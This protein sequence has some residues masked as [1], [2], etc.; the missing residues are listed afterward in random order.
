MPHAY[1]HEPTRSDTKSEQTHDDCEWLNEEDRE[2]DVLGYWRDVY[3]RR[4]TPGVIQH[5]RWD[6]GDQDN[7]DAE[8]RCR[9]GRHKRG[10]GLIGPP[11]L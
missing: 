5:E 3:R 7:S 10:G 11:V 9:D 1:T 6:V 4:L 2:E 8:H